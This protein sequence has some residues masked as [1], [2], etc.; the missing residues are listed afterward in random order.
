MRYRARSLDNEHA[1]SFKDEEIKVID[2]DEETNN[3][4]EITLRKLNQDKHKRKTIDLSAL[5]L[6]QFN[7]GMVNKAVLAFKSKLS[8]SQDDSKSTIRGEQEENM[9]NS[10]STIEAEQRENMENEVQAN[11]P[12]VSDGVVVRRKRSSISIKN[13]VRSMIERS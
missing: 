1:E 9:A 6:P 8:V 7:Q 3:S 12:S 13:R 4:M 2:E 5:R 10:T 11:I